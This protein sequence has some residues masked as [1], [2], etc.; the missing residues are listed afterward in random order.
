MS[1]ITS[2]KR[3]DINKDNPIINS[4]R[5][6]IETNFYG[7]NVVYVNSISEEIGRASCRERV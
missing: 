1:T 4:L 2:F 5:T 6:T 7:N 3:E